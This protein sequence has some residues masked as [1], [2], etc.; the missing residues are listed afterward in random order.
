MLASKSA[1]AASRTSALI[2]QTVNA[3]AEGAQLAD[4]TAQALSEAV[5]DTVSVDEN[6]IRISETTRRES[7][8]MDDIFG[9][10]NTI[11]EIVS[12]TSDSAQSAAASSQELSSQASILS[13]LI[14][15]FKLN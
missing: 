2:Q 12:R 6:I 10:I 14:S 3:I 15:E 13:N 5:S 7:E 1:E 8:Y 11:S 4:T 9:N